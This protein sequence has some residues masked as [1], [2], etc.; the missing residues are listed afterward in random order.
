MD[1]V[2]DD[3]WIPMQLR[4]RGARVLLA[5]DAIAHDRAFSDEREFGRKAR[6]LAGNYQLFSR[7]PRLLL[8][9]VNPSWFETVSH[10]ITR[11]LCPWAML[12]LLLACTAGAAG[13]TS[14]GLPSEAC[15]GCC[16]RSSRPTACGAGGPRGRMGVLARTFVVLNAAAVVGTVALR[17]RTAEDHMVG[18]EAYRPPHPKV[19]MKTASQ[20]TGTP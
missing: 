18:R 15:S 3:L 10:K 2:L 4:L 9:F 17:R 12:A 16:W 5:E 1:L 14:E 20:N 6:T 8:P 19:A 7:M 11:L 13:L